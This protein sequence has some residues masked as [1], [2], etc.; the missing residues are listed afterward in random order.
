MSQENAEIVR[1]GFNALAT[2]D[3]ESFFAL[4]DNDVEWVNPAYAVEPGTRLGIDEFRGALGRM[5]AS[6]GNI[7]VEVDQVTDASGKV[8]V[9]GRWTGEGTGSGV[10][11]ENTFSSVLTLREG[12]V[13]RYEWFRTRA[14]ALQAVGL[15]E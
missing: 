13:V 14:E 2:G 10:T 7:R 1:D 4:L 8:V 15:S 9:V 3:F 5:G 6:F 12:K 11:L